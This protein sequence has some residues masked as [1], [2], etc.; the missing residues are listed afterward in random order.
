MATEAESGHNYWA[1]PVTISPFAIC[2][3]SDVFPFALPMS[4]D[5][6]L[7]SYPLNLGREI[8]PRN[9]IANTLSDFPCGGCYKVED[10]DG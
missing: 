6:R 10:H 7:R 9:T 4:L 8:E 1:G 3:P 2:L 5:R